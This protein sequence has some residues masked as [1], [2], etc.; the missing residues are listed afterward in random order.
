MNQDSNYPGAKHAA[1]TCWS[2]MKQRCFNLKQRRFAQYGRRGITVC[3]AWNFSFANFW[4]DM[5]STWFEGA[6]LDRKNNDG[7]YNRENCQWLTKREHNQKTIIDRETV[8][9]LDRLSKHPDLT[10][11]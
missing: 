4:N 9:V 1:Y 7:P 10:D 2:M 5:G 6:S 11:R 3:A 8:L